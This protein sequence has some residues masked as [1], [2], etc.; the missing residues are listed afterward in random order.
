M[1]LYMYQAAYVADSWAAQLK[2]PQNRADSVGRAACEAVGGKLVGSWYCFGDYD[3][4]IIADV[5]DNESM[6][7]IA[8]AIA[9]GGAVKSAKTTVLMSGA[10]AVAGMKKA[11]AVTKIYKPAR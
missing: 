4:I 5:P 1:P 8:L 7:A 11:D 3:L 9:A 6:S 10:E 2:N